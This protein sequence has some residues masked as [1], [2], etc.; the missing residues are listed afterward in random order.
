[1]IYELELLK[2]FLALYE[3]LKQ[4]KSLLKVLLYSL[5]KSLILLVVTGQQLICNKVNI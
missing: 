4:N 5:S 3:I 2:H 1:M